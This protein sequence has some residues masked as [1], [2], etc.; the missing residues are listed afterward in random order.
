M[1]SPASANPTMRILKERVQRSEGTD[2]RDRIEVVGIGFSW[3]N[4]AMAQGLDQ[5]LGYNPLRMGIV[6]TALS[7]GDYIAGP[8]QRTFS[9]LFPSYRSTLADLLGLR[10]IASSVPI[11]TI[12][13]YLA[14]D[15]LQLVAATSQAFIYENAQALPR[16]MM[17]P[18]ALPA[19][20]ARLVKTGA[21]PAFNP[22]RT[23]LLDRSDVAWRSTV[24]LEAWP[25]GAASAVIRRYETTL[26]QVDVVAPRAGF[27][28]LGDLWHPW[29][30]ATIDG[31][32]VPILK[33]NVMFRSVQVPAGQHVVRFE[34]HPIS[35]ALA[36]IS[37][38]IAVRRRRDE[39][40]AGL[41]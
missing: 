27:L 12:D 3:Q 7:A 18:K 5:T 33:A 39:Q 41:K 16:V 35:G 26:V 8:D 17:V 21:W 40:P 36:Q 10:F 23:V 9:P 34:F 11:E 13:K 28:V 31:K 20:F 15:D 14:P 1:L 25:D 2:R 32:P 37:D 6:A 29:W 19:D 24:G 30:T 22:R 4:A 38:R